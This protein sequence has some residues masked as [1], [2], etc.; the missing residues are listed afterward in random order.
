MKPVAI[1]GL[2]GF[3]CRIMGFHFNDANLTSLENGN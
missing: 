3:R 1:H 2:D